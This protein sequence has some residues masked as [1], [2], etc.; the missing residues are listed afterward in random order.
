MKIFES[1]DFNG[2]Q[3]RQEFG[4]LRDW[5]NAH[6]TLGEKAIRDFF[7]HRRHL[8]AFIASSSPNMNRLDRIAFEYPLFGDFACDLVVG[9]SAGR[10][11]CFVEFEDAGP[12]SLFVRR[13]KK[14]TR[15][16]SP[17]FDHGYSQINDWFHATTAASKDP[18][19][20]PP[21]SLLGPF[22]LGL[23]ISLDNDPLAAEL[24]AFGR[25]QLL[26]ID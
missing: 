22:L 21:S 1:L 15:E 26:G 19:G 7:H 24:V 16:W 3:C 4:E 5:L 2:A 14:A 8:S 25:G 17:R 11:F 6:P 10:A 23:K 13:G 20:L 18:G 12:Q 9:D